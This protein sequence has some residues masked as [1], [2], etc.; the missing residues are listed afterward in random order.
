MG[1]LRRLSTESSADVVQ[2]DLQDQAAGRGST[3]FLI[4]VGLGLFCVYLAISYLE[5]WIQLQAV[6]EAAIGRDAL[7]LCL[8]YGAQ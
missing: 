1:R 4:A 5:A 2:I 8:Q 6:C 3:W 7:M